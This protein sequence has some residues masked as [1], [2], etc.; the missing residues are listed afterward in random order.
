MAVVGEAHVI[1][2]A[3]TNRVKPDIERAFSGLDR[4]GEREGN[5]I[6]EAF[7]RGLNSGGGRRGSIFGGKFAAEAEAARVKFQKLVQILAEHSIL[8]FSITVN[9]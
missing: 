9:L 2:R 5:K 7:D 8:D 3:I 6:S 1:V 4:I